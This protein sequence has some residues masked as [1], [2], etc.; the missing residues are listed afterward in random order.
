MADAPLH[1]KYTSLFA[2]IKFAASYKICQRVYTYGTQPFFYDFLSRFVLSWKDHV[3]QE[4]YEICA[5]FGPGG[6]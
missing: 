4:E 6:R 5:L 1:Q 3:L 2:G